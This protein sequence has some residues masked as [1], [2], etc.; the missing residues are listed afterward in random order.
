MMKELDSEIS[1]NSSDVTQT[2]ETKT[3]E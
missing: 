2:L 1:K 3:A